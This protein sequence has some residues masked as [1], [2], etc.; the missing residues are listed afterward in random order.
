MDNRRNLA[1]ARVFSNLLLGGTTAGA[2]I[3]L[4]RIWM[5]DQKERER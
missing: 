4:M 1:F 5:R 2:L 3:A